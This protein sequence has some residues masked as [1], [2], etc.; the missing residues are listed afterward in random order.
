MEEGG[1]SKERNEERKGFFPPPHPVNRGPC[2]P[3]DFRTLARSY[4][5]RNAKVEKN[6]EK[7]NLGRRRTLYELV[8]K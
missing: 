4:A 2:P 1:V 3:I 7:H 5:L 8:R 6:E